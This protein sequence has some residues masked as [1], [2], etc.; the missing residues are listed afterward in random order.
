MCGIAG[1]HGF[2]RIDLDKMIEAIQHRGPDSSGKYIEDS[3]GLGSRRLAII[4][5]EGGDQPVHNEDERIWTVFN[6]EIYNHKDLREELR[7]KGHR[8]YTGTDTEIIVHA[9][10]E[11]GNKFTERFRGM[12]AIALWDREAEKL[13]LSRDKLGKKPLYYHYNSGKLLFGSEIKSILSTSIY[14]PKLN[15]DAVHQFLAYGYKSSP[16]TLFRGVNKLKPGETLI[17]QKEDLKRFQSAFRPSKT[18]NNVKNAAEELRSILREDIETWTRENGSYSVFLSGGIDSS[19]VLALLSE[20]NVDVNTYTAA[21][22]GSKFDETVHAEQVAE[23]FNSSH[24]T[25]EISDTAVDMIP[26]LVKQYDDLMADQANIPY[27]ILSEKASNHSRVAFTGS[28]ADELFGGYEHHQIMD[29]GDRYLRKLPNSVRKPA[30][31][32]AK[33]IPKPILQQFFPYVKEL[34]PAGMKRFSKYVETIESPRKSYENV[35]AMMTEEEIT[36]LCKGEPIENVTKFEDIPVNYRQQSVMRQAIIYEK[37][38][39]LPSKNLMKTDKTGMAHGLEIR[40]PLLTS[41][42]LEFSAGMSDELLRGRGGKK[43]LKHAM[44]PYLP[45]QVLDRKK[46]R[47]LMPIHDWLTRDAVWTIEE[48]EDR[49]GLPPM[50]NEEELVS[51]TKGLDSSPLYYA[52]QLWNIANFIVWY[53]EYMQD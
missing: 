13:L 27:Y 9:Y 22:P 33:T 14:E 2:E 16:A 47:M 32:V 53:D 24:S 31:L 11:W 5:E 18:H 40:T 23:H 21:F 38:I 3:L 30:P 4:D 28:G 8:F 52:R 12:Y 37:Y 25:V 43:I 39:Q 1:Y 26:Q 15:T 17:K 49:Y 42:T 34:G 36:S 45:E 48:L 29:M 46:Q 20:I 35:N 6:G 19:A 10:E 44:K 41:R 51:I 7:S 50:I